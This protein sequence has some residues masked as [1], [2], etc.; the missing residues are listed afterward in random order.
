MKTAVLII[1]AV[2][3][4]AAC[5]ARDTNSIILVEAEG[6]S[7]HGG[8]VVDPQFMD[9]M[10]SPY[11]LAHGLGRPVADATTEADF[12]TAGNYRVWVRTKDWVAEWKGASTPG[13]FQVL[14]N[15]RALETTFGTEGA[16]WHWQDGGAVALSAGKVALALHDLTGFEGRCDA[17][18]FARD[19]K[20]VPPNAE[21]ALTA[22]RRKCLGLP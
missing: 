12:P 16:Q 10:G 2:F 3:G 18:L 19:P 13:R 15:G 1:L 14:V 7:V 6:F 8:W 22:M 17:I 20:F 5:E 9:I 11:L 4:V 21:P